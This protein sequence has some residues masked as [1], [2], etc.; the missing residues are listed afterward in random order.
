MYLESKSL[1][2]GLLI[3]IRDWNRFYEEKP[4]VAEHGMYK[5]G[6]KMFKIASW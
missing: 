3:L 6:D 5:R 4:N 1:F 2:L